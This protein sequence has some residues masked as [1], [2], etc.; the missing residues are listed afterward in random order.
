MTDSAPST[1]LVPE[2][3][4]AK[5]TL[6]S[7]I[8]NPSSP[9][10]RGGV[11]TDGKAITAL[12]LQ[13]EY[14]DL[15]RAEQLGEPHAVGPA[16]GVDLD[17]PISAAHYDISSAPGARSMTAEDRGIV[18]QFLP[19]AFAAG[20]G[21]RK[22]AEAIG[23][24]LTCDT[25]RGVDALLE[26]WFA[27]AMSRGWSDEQI[28]FA[29]EWAADFDERG[30]VPAAAP[31]GASG[32]FVGKAAVADE[33]A[34]IEALMGRQDSDYWRGPKRATLQQRYRELLAG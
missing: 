16:H 34:E 32:Q 22:V 6:E 2:A 26:Q 17:L 31:R 10:W 28:D 24:A 20:L 33:R 30:G 23:F 5:A 8:G 19:A 11:G 3:Q 1:S 15:I 21:Q 18:D 13:Q 25:S 12:E 4:S 9:Y 7:Q 14:Q 29:L 27:L